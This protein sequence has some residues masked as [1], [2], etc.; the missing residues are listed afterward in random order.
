M[1]EGCSQ[2]DSARI[3]THKQM[4]F[5]LQSFSNLG[6]K[7]IYLRF[8]RPHTYLQSTTYRR[9]H[10]NTCLMV[11]YICTCLVIIL[12]CYGGNQNTLSKINQSYYTVPTYVVIGLFLTLVLIWFGPCHTYKLIIYGLN[13]SNGLAFHSNLAPSYL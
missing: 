3:R 12:G 4:G 10:K 11:L 2:P 7:F 5:L 6:F 8:P 13:N 9:K 1:K